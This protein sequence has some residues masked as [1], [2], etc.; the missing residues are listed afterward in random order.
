MCCL[1]Q[2]FL[3]IF[4]GEPSQ[5]LRQGPTSGLLTLDDHD[6]GIGVCRVDHGFGYLQGGIFIVATLR[7]LD[8]QS[9]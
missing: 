7:V 6:K 2:G 4:R 1:H 9:S 8:G 3:D 5:D